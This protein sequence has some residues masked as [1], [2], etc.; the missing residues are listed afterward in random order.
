MPMEISPLLLASPDDD[1]PTRQLLTALFWRSSAPLV[2]ALLLPGCGSDAGEV[3]NTADTLTDGSLNC[4]KDGRWRPMSA[5]KLTQ[6]V[7]FIAL[8][9]DAAFPHPVTRQL[10]AAGAPCSSAVDRRVCE[11]EMRRLS[12]VGT[13]PQGSHFLTVQGD[14]VR[15][16]QT[17][18]EKLSL[19]GSIDTPDEALLLLEHQGL[20]IGCTVEPTRVTVRGDGYRVATSTSAGDSCPPSR[21]S[22]VMDVDRKG[23]VTEI[24]TVNMGPG[25]TSGRRP[26]NLMAR[27][28]GAC[29]VS[30]LGRYFARSARLEAASVAAFEQLAEELRMFGAPRALVE[31]ARRAAEEEVRH[32]QVTSTLAERYGARPVAA[33]MAR[34]RLRGRSEVA[35]DNAVE[36]CALETYSAYLATVQ[37]RLTQQHALGADLAQIARDETGHAAFSWQLA[38]WLEPQLDRPVAR[39]IAQRRLAALRNLGTAQV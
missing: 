4:D 22:Y 15:A 38:A 30:A 17:L 12:L 35:L 33:Q 27:R 18:E 6:P 36:G 5:L 11:A 21:A 34:R 16:Y 7:D 2:V 29:G 37:A 28:G 8:R 3:R 39:S 20:P 19:L 24:E 9:R 13:D 25:C 26:P 1:Q 14:V 32:A 23:K 31:S 10:D